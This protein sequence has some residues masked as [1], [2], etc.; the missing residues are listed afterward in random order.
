[1]RDVILY[2][3]TSC[4]IFIFANIQIK[5]ENFVGHFFFLLSK[6]INYCCTKKVI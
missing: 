3:R 4:P 1:V 5:N 2:K 6:Q